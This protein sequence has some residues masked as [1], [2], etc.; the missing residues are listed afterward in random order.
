MSQES[1][2]MK[3]VIVQ[4]SKPIIQLDISNSQFNVSSDEIRALPI[5]EISDI[6]DLQAGV[7]GL[8]IRGG[9]T[10]ESLFRVDG[11]SY[12]D[13]RSNIPYTS[14][15]IGIIKEIQ[16]QTGGFNA[17]YGNIRSGE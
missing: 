4:A 5:D 12:T 6:L 14:I 17:E 7:N 11:F 9:G 15:P 2:K 13:E 8:S 1:I 10:R 16:V 3:E